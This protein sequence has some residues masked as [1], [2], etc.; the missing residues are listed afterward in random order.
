MSSRREWQET[1]MK[2]ALDVVK[3]GA[4]SIRDVGNQ[5]KIPESSIRLRKRKSSEEFAK[6]YPAGRK[7]ELSR[8]TEKSLADCIQ[9][10]CQN[11]FSPKADEVRQ[12]VQEYL[13]RNKISTRFAANMPGKHWLQNFMKRNQLSLKKA[14]LISTARKSN[15][16]K[17]FLI[18]GFYDLLQKLIEEYKFEPS[19]IWNC[20]ESGFPYDPDSCLVVGLR[21]KKTFKV[22]H[23][24]G[25]QNTTVLACAL[26]MEQLFRPW[27]YLKAKIFNLHGKVSIFFTN[28]VIML[29]TDWSLW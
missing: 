20:D 16:S 6:P 27:S 3:R 4:V 21:G 19:Q 5:F 13:N 1:D 25:R 2:R 15:T 22:I 10:L 23:G 29:G 9:V 8:E 24:P 28:T 17:P 11:G 12:L 18:F 26:L 7:Q 14:N